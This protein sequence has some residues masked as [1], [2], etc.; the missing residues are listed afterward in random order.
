[1]GTTGKLLCEKNLTREEVAKFRNA[2]GN[3]YM[4]E[5]YFDSIHLSKN[6]GDDT[7]D[8]FC[9]YI[10]SSRR[11]FLINHLRFYPHYLGNKVKEIHV[12]G[13]HDSALDITEDAEIKVNFTYSVFWK[14]FESKQENQDWV[15]DLSEHIGEDNPMHYTTSIIICG[16]L[17]LLCAVILLYLRYYFTQCHSTHLSI[18]YV[19]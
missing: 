12:V 3:K 18:P 10:C 4:Y 17:C 19:V 6:I 7:K 1:M 16:W 8:S 9:D 13:D 11:F 15:R 14:E 5:M 2:I